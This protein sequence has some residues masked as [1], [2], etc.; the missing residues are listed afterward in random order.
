MQ[1]LRAAWPERL[2]GVATRDLVFLDES[3]CNRAMTRT[4]ARSLAGTRAFAAAPRNWGDNVSII[5]ALSLEGPLSSQEKVMWY[6]VPTPSRMAVTSCQ[7][8]SKLA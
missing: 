4:H 5:S 8:E 7:S 6:L 1:A 3:G 2:A